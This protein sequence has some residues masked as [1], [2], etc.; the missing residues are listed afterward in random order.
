LADWKDWVY[1][2]GAMKADIETLNTM[3]KDLSLM[4]ISS[5]KIFEYLSCSEIFS[6]IDISDDVLTYLHNAA[7]N[8]TL[9]NIYVPYQFVAR[10]AERYIDD[11]ATK[12]SIYK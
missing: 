7:L 4:N 9:S 1:C 11:I 12:F 6:N 3:W 5:Y 2:K 8:D 10:Y